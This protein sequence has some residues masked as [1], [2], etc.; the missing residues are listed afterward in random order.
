MPT[1]P[2]LTRAANSRAAWPLRVKI[3]TP[4]P[5]WCFGGQRE[6]FLEVL[7]AHDLQ[8]RAEDLVVIAVHLRGDVVEQRR[9]DEEAVLVALQREAAPVDDQFAA[10]L[11]ALRDPASIFSLCACVTTGRNAR[12]DR[13]RRRP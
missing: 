12:R 7:R 8:H 3:A 9:A 5:Y 13:S 6:R 1:M 4:L 2:T 10:F 11:D